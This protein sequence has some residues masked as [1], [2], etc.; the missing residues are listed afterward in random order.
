M[1]LFADVILPVPFETFT[2][3]VPKEMEGQVVEGSRVLVPLG[4]TKRYAGIVLRL[5]DQEPQGVLIK[6]IMEVLNAE[7]IVTPS[8]FRFWQWIANYYM[9]PLGD[10]YK[11]AFPGIL[12]K[13]DKKT[14]TKSN[15]QFGVAKTKTCHSDGELPLLS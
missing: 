14:K 12:K 1:S 5:H 13:V 6:S 11:A 7:P 8:Q 4:K 9:A 15:L 10:V 2:Y 3:A